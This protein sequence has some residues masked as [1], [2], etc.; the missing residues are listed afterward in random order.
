MRRK[1]HGG[2][3]ADGGGVGEHTTQPKSATSRDSAIQGIAAPFPLK[4]AQ[5]KAKVGASNDPAEHEADR[6][7]DHV[8]SG[9]QKAPPPISSGGQVQ[10]LANDVAKPANDAAKPTS[11]AGKSTSGSGAAKAGGDKPVQ[12]AETKEKKPADT[13]QRWNLPEVERPSGT[14]SIYRKSKEETAG[15]PVQRKPDERKPT[16]DMDAAA[17]HAIANKGQGAPMNPGTRKNLES[18]MGKDLSDV[19]VHDDSAAHG[20]AEALN[21][22]AFTH[23]SD[24][25][26]GK[27]ESQN[28]TKLMAHEAAHVVQQT[29]DANRQLVQRKEATPAETGAGDV[30]FTDKKLGEVK[31]KGASY[32]L[33]IPELQVPTFKLQATGTS[34]LTLPKK[35]DEPR[36]DDQRTL[37]EKEATTGKGIDDEIDAM[38]KKAPAMNVHGKDVIY[39]VTKE[40][41]F[42]V[43]G[44]RQTIKQRALRPTW[45]KK[46]AFETYDVDHIK[47]LQLGGENDVKSNMWLLESGANQASGRNIK[48]E[49]NS[50]IVTLLA[51]A[52][53]KD[54]VWDKMPDVDVARRDY[55]ITFTTVKGG[56]EPTGKPPTWDLKDIQAGSQLKGLQVLDKNQIKSRN[57]EGTASKVVIFTN[58]SGGGKRVSE[59]WKDADAQKPVDWHFGKM[60][61]ADTLKRDKTSGKYKLHVDAFKESHLLK[62]F[63]TDFDVQD[64]DA[65]EFGGFISKISVRNQLLDKLDATGASPITLPDPELTDKGLIGRGKLKPSIRP[66]DKLEVD[67]VF[68]GDNIYLSKIFTA[69]DFN[70]PGPIKVTAANLEVY[71]GTQSVGA[72]GD[73]FFEIAGVGN[74]KVK[75]G[76]TPEGPLIS[77]EFVF[78]KKLFDDATA[79]VEYKAGKFSG[80]GHLSI[81]A[82]KIKGI[83]SASI[84]ATFA[85][86]AIDA[87]GSVIPDI[88]VVEQADLS[89]H[90]DPKGGL[91]IGGDLQ[92]KKDIPG[93]SGGSIHAEVTKK[94]DRYI[95]KASGEV[96]PKIPGITSKLVASYDDGAFDASITAGFEKGM[97]KGSVLVGITNRPMGEDGKPAGPPPAKA[98]KTT[99][100]GGGTVTLRLAPWLQATAAIRFLPNGE[101][102]V[103][104]KIGLPSAIDLFDEK[105]FDKNLLSIGIDIPIFGVSVLGQHIGVFLNVGGGLDLSAGIGPGQLQDVELGVTY[106][107]AHEEDTKVFG[108]AALHIPAHAGLRM[109]V[110]AALG[111][112][113]P[114]IDAQAGLELGGELG[115]DGALH[116][117]VDVDWTPSK[118]LVLDANAEIYAE[119]KFK[120]DITGYVL[121]EA[122]LLVKT[123][124]L[125]EK[126]WKLA[127]M[128]YGSGLRFG[129]KLPVHYEEGKPF[130]V[131]LSDIQFETPK[132]DPVDVLKGIFDKIV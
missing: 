49:K 98:D 123:V 76:I 116:A 115:V 78:D 48:A 57:L 67:V 60:F 22:R 86:E 110:H 32:A 59:G 70:F 119:P 30:A 8:A 41:S 82:G 71:A 35:T 106:N 45:D 21:A 10:R 99:L 26:M 108:H 37:W 69:G 94:E 2:S 27:G 130:N 113:I 7:A 34:S 101:V 90:Y 91:T 131:S 13:V 19:R 102:E 56:L 66:F 112:G 38:F 72:R 5:R 15:Q 14:A 80:S 127:Q 29:G 12:R 50:K 128:E 17:S 16:E 85:E 84:D 104:G 105:K 97:L 28:D 31:K 54:K 100:Y 118:G 25:W 124:T 52:T 107:P 121:V 81:K 117:Q 125:Y 92:L 61:H 89:M 68:D 64:M 51:A 23:G 44:T 63:Q 122:D 39:T 58:E 33:T 88:P 47:E 95:V 79:K 132:V 11:E 87:K 77:G 109:S 3:G 1:T 20:A 42:Y 40:S 96:T 36:P 103:T 46:G 6:V 126:K 62:K 114:V 18:G 9:S 24:I 73:V 93:V 74:G 43:V 53:G 65:I 4:G 120:F 129:L 111:A 55:D 75:G 83:K